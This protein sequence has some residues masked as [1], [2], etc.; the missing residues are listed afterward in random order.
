MLAVMFVSITAAARVRSVH[1]STSIVTPRAVLWIGAHPDD[2]A[3]IAPLLASWC[4]DQNARCGML[5]LTRGEAAACLKPEGCSPNVATVRSAEAGAASQYFNAECVLLALPDGGGIMPPT[6]SLVGRTD[7]ART[8]AAYIAAFAPEIII[9]FDPRHGTTCHPDH[10]AAGSIVMEAA[11]AVS[12]RPEVYF[13][14]TR[15]SI[16]ANPTVIHFTSASP[17]VE[18]YDANTILNSTQEPAW[19]AIIDDMQHHG[20]Q[21]DAAFVDAIRNVPYAERFVY[22]AK[23][24]SILSGRVFTCP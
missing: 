20:S 11:A 19:N 1:H 7:T 18:R 2:E 5:I 17:A 3:V 14:E 21:F 6:W 22:I 23:A 4:R 16:T 12:P 10:R 8:L 15:I 9:T 24:E 13:V